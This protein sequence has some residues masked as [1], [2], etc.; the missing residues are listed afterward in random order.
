MAPR[1]EWEARS[2]ARP[3][4]PLSAANAGSKPALSIISQPPAE[5]ARQLT[6]IE[7]NIYRAIM[8]S[9]LTSLVGAGCKF[10]LGTAWRRV[11]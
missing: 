10:L 8:P 9:E 11:G 1:S 4:A 6:L 2:P 7:F 3:L 5:V